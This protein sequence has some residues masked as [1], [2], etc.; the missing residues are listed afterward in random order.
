VDRARD[1]RARTHSPLI[2]RVR[3][4]LRPPRALR[5]TRAGWLFF[6]ITFGVGFAALNTGNNLLYL[7]LSLMLAFLILSGVLSESALRGITVARQLPRELYAGSHNPVLLQISNHLKRVPAFAI[8]IEDLLFEVDGQRDRPDKAPAVGRVFALRVAPR[9]TETRRYTFSPERRGRI[10]FAGFR[11]ST[12]FPFG[13]FLKSRTFEQPE[14]AL[15]FPEVELVR[16]SPSDVATRDTGDELAGDAGLG[17]DVAGLREFE[18][19]DS[20]RR[21]HWKSS[22]RRGSLLVTQVEDE[23]DGRVEV[24]L[25]TA[26]P[27]D[28]A[29]RASF[30]RR[31]QYAASEVV[32]H[33]DAGLSAALRTDSEQLPLGRGDRH[34]ICLLSFLALVE[35]DPAPAHG[36]RSVAA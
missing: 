16:A 35:P 20:P 9:K 33:L 6:A 13:L 21:V 26:T 28:T 4:W 19:G 12:R 25:R 8:V 3:R 15:V 11:V 10:H 29:L 7:V 2:A 18:Y 23:R 17:C 24:Y 27:P 32:S 34:R 14:E 30:E 36:T 5:P 31:V 1:P 22:L